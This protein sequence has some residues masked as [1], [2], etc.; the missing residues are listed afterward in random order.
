MIEIVRQ[1]MTEDDFINAF[2]HLADQEATFADYMRLDAYFCRQAMRHAQRKDPA[3]VQLA[4]T[5]MELMF[6]FV[7]GALKSWAVDTLK[8]DMS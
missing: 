3:L 6:G 5:V 2:L 4:R 1:I 7:D 8:N